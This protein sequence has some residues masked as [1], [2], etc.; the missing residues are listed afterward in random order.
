M[1]TGHTTGDKQRVDRLGHRLA[2]GTGLV[3]IIDGK[4]HHTQTKAFAENHF[5]QV[6]QG[7]LARALS[8]VDAQ[9]KR[10]LLLPL[11]RQNPGR[12]RHINRFEQLFQTNI[13][14]Q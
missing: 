13:D 12:Q 7:R 4:T 8:T 10:P 1:G 14:L 6:E 3:K 11:T 5:Q 9:H 2:I